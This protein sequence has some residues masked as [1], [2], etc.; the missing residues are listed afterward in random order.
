MAKPLNPLNALIHL[1]RQPGST[2][3]VVRAKKKRSQTGVSD[4][5][6][7][8]EPITDENLLKPIS[9]KQSGDPR[10]RSIVSPS[11]AITGSVCAMLVVDD[12]VE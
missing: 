2:R 7:A 12:E 5:Y 8:Q 3:K 6:L 9:S 10:S 4:Q 11:G 1:A